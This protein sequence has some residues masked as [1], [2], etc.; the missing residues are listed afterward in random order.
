MVKKAIFGGTFDPI[1]IAHL[2]VAHKAKEDLGLD[3][4]IFMPSANPPHKQGKKV[5]DAHLRYEMVKM[6]IRGE[7]GF[8]ISDYEM[9]STGLSYTYKTLQ[10]F[11]EL[12]PGT[13]WH[14]IAGLDSLAD[15]HKWQNPDEIFELC[16]FVVYNRTGYEIKDMKNNKYFK[17]SVLLEMPI[18]D[19]SSTQ[20]RYDIS[21]G[22]DVSSL[23]PEPVGN[24]I[25]E[26]DLYR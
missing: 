25:K 17:K 23:V 1:H 19:I 20:I 14:F 8:Q 24:F 6:A 18:L 3:A 12:E 10:H 13:D 22:R 7:R 16:H 5:T 11:N 2:Y 15:I 9:N 21:A 26:L 4:V